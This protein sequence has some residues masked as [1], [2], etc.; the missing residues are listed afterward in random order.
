MQ[1]LMI[2]RKIVPE[3]RDDYNL[4]NV[5]KFFSPKGKVVMIRSLSTLILKL[6]RRF[7]NGFSWAQGH[8]PA[9]AV[10]CFV[11]LI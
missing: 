10:H 8:S 3:P 1:P 2:V 11:P 5:K 9:P 4:N 6:E 7:L